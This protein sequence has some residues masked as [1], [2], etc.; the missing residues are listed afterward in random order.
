MHAQDGQFIATVLLDLSASGLYL[1]NRTFRLTVLTRF[2]DEVSD[3]IGISLGSMR[4]N[5]TR[6]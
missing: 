1:H 2:R 6:K 5:K 4:E 3:A